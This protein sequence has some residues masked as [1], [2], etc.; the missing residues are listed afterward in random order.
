LTGIIGRA[1]FNTCISTN[2]QNA[3]VT[4]SSVGVQDDAHWTTIWKP[5]GLQ[6]LIVY[7]KG[8]TLTPYYR[9]FT[10]MKKIDDAAAANSVSASVRWQ[11]LAASPLT[12]EFILVTQNSQE[13]I[14]AQVYFNRQ[15]ISNLQ[16]NDAGD[17]P[18]E[19]NRG[20]DAA[21]ESLSGRGM[22]VYSNGTT[23]PQYRIWASNTWSSANSINVGAN[24]DIRWIRLVSRPSTNEIMC[25]ARWRKSPPSAANYSSAII[26]NGAIWTNLIT[27]ETNCASTIN[28]EQ[29]DA[30]YSSN[31]AMVVYINGSSAAQRRFPK[32]RTYNAVTNGWSGQNTMSTLGAEPAWMRVAYSFN[33]AQAYACFMR[34]RS[35]HPRL[36]G[37]YWNGISWGSYNTFF[38][39]DMAINKRCFD[40]A[41]SSRT[42]TLMVAYS[43]WTMHAQSYMISTN[44]GITAR[45]GSL[46]S[47]DD[48]QWC[49]LKAD[50][51]SSDFYYL[52]LDDQDDV[53]FQRWNGSSWSLFPE[54]ETG[55]A[56]DYCNID[57]VFRRDNQ[58]TNSW[59]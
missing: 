40:I 37:T 43:R 23:N 9:T 48:G 45:Y 52:A 33:G 14:W 24:G 12:N 7:R 35:P 1:S 2:N 20:F 54:L 32:Y 56:D 50:P 18:S 21:Y 46:V 39:A 25:L 10:N 15:W 28:Y 30:T 51:F 4:V 17:T 8:T 57:F 11:R 3:E 38:D 44:G 36:S 22:V 42:N 5:G 29:M 19:G 31:S 49:V 59:W 55:S 41:W 6:G 58:V 27:L 47:T 34:Q 13:E 16:L 53:N 26:W